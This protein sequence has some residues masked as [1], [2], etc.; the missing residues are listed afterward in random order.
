MYKKPKTKHYQAYTAQAY[1]ICYTAAACTWALL[2]H[3]L[4]G[5][6]TDALTICYPQLWFSYGPRPD[7]TRHRE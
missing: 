5:K 4:R 7:Y 1:N 6:L 3:A 2:L